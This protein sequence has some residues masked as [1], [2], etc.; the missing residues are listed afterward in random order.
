[1][2]VRIPKIAL[3]VDF[4]VPASF[5]AARRVRTVNA[6]DAMDS[7]LLYADLPHP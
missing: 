4:A 7:V 1:M 2:K 3:C 5:A 6:S